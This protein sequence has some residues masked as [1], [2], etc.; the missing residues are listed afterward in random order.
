MKQ[1]LKL[2]LFTMSLI[3]LVSCRASKIP[4]APSIAKF[5]G[6]NEKNLSQKEINKCSNQKMMQYIYDCIQYPEGITAESLKGMVVIGFDVLPSGELDNVLINRQA[7]LGI[8]E[9]VKECFINM[10]KWDP[11]IS[12]TG[13]KLS[14]KHAVPVSFPPIRYR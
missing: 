10:P 5:S 12:S 4:K 8:E 2:I 1:C 6:C 7:N 3:A 14:T 11:S 9:E 13:E